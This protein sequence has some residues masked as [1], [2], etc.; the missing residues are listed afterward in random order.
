MKLICSKSNLLTGVQ[1][2]SKAVSNK[3]TMSI[4]ECIL[5]D[6]SKGYITLTGNRYHQSLECSG[7]KRTIKTMP[8]SEAERHYKMCQRCGG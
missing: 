2:V 7:L 4:L 5:V 3:T 6:A 8:R 1:I